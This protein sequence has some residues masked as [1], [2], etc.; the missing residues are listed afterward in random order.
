MLSSSLD[1]GLNPAGALFPDSRVINSHVGGFYTPPA[2]PRMNNWY[3][4]RVKKEPKKPPEKKKLKA[5]CPECGKRILGK[6]CYFQRRMLCRKCFSDIKY[7]D[8]SRR[9]GVARG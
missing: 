4:N 8:G 3:K 1:E 2:L 6:I 9:R 7:S 5:K